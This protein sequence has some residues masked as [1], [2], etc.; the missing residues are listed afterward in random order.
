MTINATFIGQIIVFLILLWF[1]N[2]FVVPPLAQ[3]NAARQK[4]IADGLA[5]AEQG[6]KALDEA[7]ARADAVVR[8]ARERA[9]QILDQANR[10]SGE[11]VEAAKST[12]VHEG[13]RLVANARAEAASETSRARDALRREVA[14]LAV[15][16]ASKLIEREIDPKAHAQL[17]DKLAE[18]IARG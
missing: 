1:F 3:A 16:G 6:Q 13:E 9:N 17:L 8:E 5:A 11:I 14:T 18:E 12:A 2:R 4:K 7:Q 15:T 10:R